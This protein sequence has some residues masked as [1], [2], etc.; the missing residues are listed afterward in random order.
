MGKALREDYYFD[1]PGPQNTEDVIESV[2]KRVELTG[3][4]Y[5]IVASTS[6][7][8]AL[9]FAKALE[10]KAK[11]V[12]VSG[13]PY[14]REWKLE[15]PC[16]K[17]GYQRELEKFGVAIID[18]APYVFRNSVLEGIQWTPE[19]LVRETL[20][21]FGQGLK[22]AVEVVLLA[23]ACGFVPPYEDVIGVGGTRKGADT[24]IILR[25]TYPATIFSKETEKRL[26]IR[27]II[28]MPLYK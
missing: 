20:Y 2:K 7:E 4:K 12:S 5:V 15:W 28:A 24:A 21:C 22:V 27:E 1:E 9:K 17:S 10:G 13:L 18:R 25:A 14:R 26:E 6:G 19:S 8:T 3:I 11:V 16:L 23:V